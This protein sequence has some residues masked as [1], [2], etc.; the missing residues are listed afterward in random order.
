MTCDLSEDSSVVVQIHA[1]IKPD[2]V[3][4]LIDAESD[5]RFHTAETNGEEC[6]ILCDGTRHPGI[7]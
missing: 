4:D 7:D 1:A 6:H 2:D 3:E 5:H